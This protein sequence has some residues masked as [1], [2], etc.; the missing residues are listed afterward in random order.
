MSRP[1]WT[2][3]EAA[4][5]SNGTAR[6][7]FS[8]HGISIDTRT[9]ER[10]DLFVALSGDNRD[11]HDF[12]DAAFANGAAAALV[13]QPGPWAG[14]VLTVRD[15]LD[16]LRGLA[17]EG[18]ARTR[19]KIVAVTGSVGK[20]G[21]KEALRLVFEGFGATH[22]SAAS[23]NNH[24]GV[25][26]SLARMPQDSAFGVFEIGMNHAGEIA[27]LAQ[28]AQPH[29]AIVTTVEPVHIEHFPS[30]EAIADEKGDIFKGLT[31]GGVA[32]INR[33]NAYFTL[34]RG[35]AERLGARVLGFGSHLE[36]DA[37]LLALEPE[38]EGSH[39]TAMICGRPFRYHLGAPG[40]HVALNTLAVILAADALGL[41]VAAAA[42]RLAA[43]AP[44]KG[45]GAREIIKASSLTVTLI[46][47]SYNANPASMRAALSLLGDTQP[48]G[49]GRRIAV[50]GDMLELGA[51]GP[52]YHAELAGPIE[53]A[54]VDL[55]YVSGALMEHL[56]DVLPPY[57]R[58]HKAQTSAE[59]AERLIADLRAGDVIM[60]KGSFGSRMGK[61]VE[62]L[63][64]LSQ[65]IPAVR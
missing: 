33:D 11:G 14:P 12:V 51:G 37:Q 32:V 16:G 39:V 58:G 25:P 52:A 30:V 53:T 24:W 49:A 38:N 10:G 35:K 43:L 21:T 7:A 26:L 44:P 50:L 64:G 47:E 57:R 36:A 65:K 62:A 31:P 28:L 4:R 8:A 46:D 5:A 34:L 20:T 41:D 29:V 56:W 60:V 2:A 59:L 48:Q 9:L 55:V 23:Y 6:G 17:R 42:A 3:E 63:Q 54:D 19:A 18:R 40:R 13:S 22:A 61:V 15:T 1:L 45:R 27:P